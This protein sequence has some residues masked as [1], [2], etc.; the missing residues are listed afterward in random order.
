MPSVT[1]IGYGATWPGAAR[2]AD[3][4]GLRRMIQMQGRLDGARDL[5]NFLRKRNGEQVDDI[6]EL[7]KEIRRRDL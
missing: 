5:I 1:P 7:K 4:I 2:A 3:W 6:V